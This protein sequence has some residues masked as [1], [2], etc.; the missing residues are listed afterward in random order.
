MRRRG[1]RA[2]K[3]QLEK[4]SRCDFLRS[5]GG[6]EAE[7]GV[8]FSP[9]VFAAAFDA[10][11]GVAEGLHAGENGRAL[12]TGVE[13]FPGDSAALEGKVVAARFMRDSQIGTGFAPFLAMGLDAAAADAVVCEQMGEFM[14]ERAL[15]LGG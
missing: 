10:G 15:N 2:K 5:L 4:N 7:A 9:I 14:A 11:G 6:T 1:R 13:K 3:E 12:W 8:V